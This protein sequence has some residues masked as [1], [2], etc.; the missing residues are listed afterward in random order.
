MSYPIPEVVKAARAK[1]NAKIQD[2]GHYHFG[3][4]R[5]FVTEKGA[6]FYWKDDKRVYIKKDRAIY[7]G[8]DIF[9][10][11]KGA[12]LKAPP[13]R[14]YYARR[15]VDSNAPVPL[16]PQRPDD[17]EEIPLA[18]R[19]KKK[20]ST[21]KSVSVKGSARPNSRATAQISAVGE[22]ERKIMELKA[23]NLH[24]FYLLDNKPV[25]RLF[26]KTDVAKSNDLDSKTIEKYLSFDNFEDGKSYFSSDA[27]VL[28]TKNEAERIY[29]GLWDLT[30]APPPP[31]KDPDPWWYNALPNSIVNSA[32]G[33]RRV[34]LMEKKSAWCLRGM[35]ERPKDM[36]KFVKENTMSSSKFELQM[37]K[38]PFY[39]KGNKDQ[40]KTNFDTYFCRIARSG[41]L[42]EY[43]EKTN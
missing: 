5:V 2:T 1:R 13:R 34:E 33:R 26:R 27:S 35:V 43:L 24:Y 7:Y 20:K 41:H 21:T 42:K 14:T 22:R 4:K 15:Y 28:G 40:F 10:A 25:N 3:R 39:C 6:F 23:I 9:Q 18:P 30:Q 31:E 8:Y 32:E 12:S 16:S 29:K 37:F 17:D 36:F 38:V 11:P 19:K